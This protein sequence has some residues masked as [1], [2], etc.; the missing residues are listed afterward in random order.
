[1][2]KSLVERGYEVKTIQHAQ[3][4]LSTDF[5]EALEELEI[6]IRSTSVP[7]SELIFGGGGKTKLV[8]RLEQRFKSRGW[9]KHNFDL[10]KLVDGVETQAMSHEI[11][12]VKQ[13]KA[14]T[15]ALEIEWNNKD[16]FFDRDLQNFRQLHADGAISVGIII[17]RGSS[18]QEGIR[19]KI[20]SFAEA[21]EI[22]DIDNL[23]QFYRPTRSQIRD[24]TQRHQ[25]G[26]S[27]A[28]AWADRFVSSKFGQSTTHWQKL[29]DR[30]NRGI[31]NPCPLLL[32]GIP[33]SVVDDSDLEQK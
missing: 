8:Q 25:A 11:D 22:N 20:A 7:I 3:S 5:S 14:G 32:I 30:I 29:I 9:I 27:F 6:T 4:I 12:H 19:N 1:M 31:G 33:I 26:Y 15:V 18:F 10:R 13:F 16:P 17:T 2:L 24:I 28:E 21:N 23:R